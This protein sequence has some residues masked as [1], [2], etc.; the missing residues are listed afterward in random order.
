MSFRSIYNVFSGSTTSVQNIFWFGQWC[1]EK[2]DPWGTLWDIPRHGQKVHQLYH[3]AFKAK[4]G[5]VLPRAT[6]HLSEKPY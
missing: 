5:S 2:Q 4:A 3:Q 1:N 6:D